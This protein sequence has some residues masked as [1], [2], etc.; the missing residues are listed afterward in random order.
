MNNGN[1]IS[2]LEDL[3]TNYGD[4]EVDAGIVDISSDTNNV[5][6][7]F[8]LYPYPDEDPKPYKWTVILDYNNIA[9]DIQYTI[10]VDTQASVVGETLPLRLYKKSDGYVLE[11]LPL[12]IE[13]T[14]SGDQGSF[15]GTTALSQLIGSQIKDLI[16][17]QNRL[18]FLTTQGLVASKTGDFMDFIPDDLNVYTEADPFD[19]TFANSGDILEYI[20]PFTDQLVVFGRHGQYSVFHSGL[21]S[22]TNLKIVPATNYDIV[23]VKPAVA[24]SEIYF[25]VRSDKDP[26]SFKIKKFIVQP[27]TQIKTAYD[28]TPHLVSYLPDTITQMVY[29]TQHDILV[30]LSDDSE[31]SFNNRQNNKTLYLLKQVFNQTEVVQQAV[32]KFTF[33]QPVYG[34]GTSAD[35]DSL[36]LIFRSL[37]Q[38]GNYYYRL[39]EL[40]LL[41]QSGQLSIADKYLGDPVMLDETYYF[42]VELTYAIP[43]TLLN[44]DQIH[45]FNV[46]ELSAFFLAPSGGTFQLLTGDT[47][48]YTF[49]I[50]DKGSEIRLRYPRIS[51]TDVFSGA[52]KFS[53]KTTTENNNLTFLGFQLTLRQYPNRHWHGHLLNT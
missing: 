26:H 17:Y 32:F 42:P 5:Y 35:Q 20:L 28:V 12:N 23:P 1:L 31:Q 19:V 44:M 13:V 27:N 15:L 39:H 45:Y 43:A 38:L 46:Q 4:A 7:T 21:F 49:N 2:S 53:I 11:H 14:V 25:L 16:V 52:A 36:Y 9:F 8:K 3:A 30:M 24:G 34:I 22:L 40:P 18:V 50:S 29:L 6:F 48:P 41:Q 47:T 51:F 10:S 37:G 33:N